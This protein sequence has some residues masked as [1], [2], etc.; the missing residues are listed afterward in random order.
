MGTSKGLLTNI[1][2]G[3]IGAFV[4]GW[5]FNRFGSAGV[6]GFNIYSLLVAIAGAIVLLVIVRA[7]SRPATRP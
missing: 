3:I 2:V 6:T 4:G 7:F 1:I 5:I